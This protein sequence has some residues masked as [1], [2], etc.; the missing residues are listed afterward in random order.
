MRNT[1][2]RKICCGQEL[3][4]KMTALFESTREATVQAAAQAAMAYYEE[5]AA[6][7]TVATRATSWHTHTFEVK[8]FTCL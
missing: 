2:H 4:A 5:A 7:A 8:A 1:E 6:V 3:D